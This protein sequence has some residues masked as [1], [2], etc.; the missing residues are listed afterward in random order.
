MHIDF[1]CITKNIQKYFKKSRKQTRINGKSRKLFEIIE[2]N[3]KYYIF[4]Y[5]SEICFSRG[6]KKKSYKFLT[7]HPQFPIPNPKIKKMV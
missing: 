4:C 5:F 3:Q 2:N 6:T 1:R 7:I